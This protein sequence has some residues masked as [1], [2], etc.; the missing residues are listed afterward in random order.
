MLPCRLSTKISLGP[1][2]TYHGYTVSGHGLT[3]NASNEQI[4]F[5]LSVH[6]LNRK[7]TIEIGLGADANSLS[8]CWST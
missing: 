1:A 7:R 4:S 6:S 3:S 2:F 8:Y 5:A